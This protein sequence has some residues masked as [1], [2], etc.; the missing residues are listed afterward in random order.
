M[1][2]WILEED[3][4]PEYFWDLNK[5]QPNQQQI[6]AKALAQTSKAGSMFYKSR[7]SQ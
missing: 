4:V 3:T 6:G 7:L 1:N 2:Q 5:N